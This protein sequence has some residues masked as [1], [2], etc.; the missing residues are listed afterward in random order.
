MDKVINYQTAK[1]QYNPIMAATLDKKFD[2]VKVLYEMG[3]NPLLVNKEG[4]NCIHIAAANNDV[5][6]L[7][8]LLK[9]TE[10][11]KGVVNLKSNDGWTA[12]HLAAI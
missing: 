7:N 11:I 4:I 9:K 2:S 8:F 12:A 3:S 6:V 5:Q 1:H 10:Q